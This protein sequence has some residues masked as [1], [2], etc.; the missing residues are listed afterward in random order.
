M[1]KQEFSAAV[2]IAT[3]AQDLSNVDDSILYGCGL[4]EFKFPVYVTVEMVAKLIRW[5]CCG[6][7]SNS[8]IVDAQELDN[9]AHIARR[10]FQIV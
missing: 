10:K 1:T 4:S 6:L 2:K 9:M 8:T 5:Q 7:F 3:S